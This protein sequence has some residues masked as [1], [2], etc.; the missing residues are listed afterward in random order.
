MA[1]VHRESREAFL[2]FAR[3]FARTVSRRLRDGGAMPEFL[4]VLL[5]LAE[6]GGM[7]ETELAQRLAMRPRAVAAAVERLEHDGLVRRTPFRANG[8]GR[9]TVSW[10][11]RTAGSVIEEA[12][13]H[14]AEIAMTGLVEDDRGALADFARRAADNLRAAP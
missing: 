2:A 12:V 14:T 7:S 4:S 11:V 3:L 13:R 9:V 10:R 1:R 8:A 5:L 6:E